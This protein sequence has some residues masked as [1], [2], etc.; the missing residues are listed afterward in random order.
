MREFEEFLNIMEIA[1]TAD[2][3]DTIFLFL[4]MD[5]SKCVE[6]KEFCRRLKR[7]G[8]TVIQKEEEFILNLHAAIK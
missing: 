5:G 4:D 6:Y 8:V 1:V 7:A 3:L 2:E